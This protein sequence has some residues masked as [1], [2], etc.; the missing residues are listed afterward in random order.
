MGGEGTTQGCEYQEAGIIEDHLRG[1]LPNKAKQIWAVWPRITYQNMRCERF[2]T[3]TE[4]ILKDRDCDFFFLN[5]DSGCC[6]VYT[7][8]L[9]RSLFMFSSL[10]FRDHC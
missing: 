6:I 7:D 8:I 1:W 4:C 9:I 10:K 2:Q 5:W 3:V